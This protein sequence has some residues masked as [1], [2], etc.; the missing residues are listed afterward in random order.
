VT[1]PGEN[2]VRLLV[3]GDVAQY[4]A[5]RLA[6]LRDHPEAYSASFELESAM[7][8]AFFIARLGGTTDGAFAG[9]FGGFVGE[10]L[11]GITGM[12]QHP[13][14]KMRHGA[15]VVSVYVDPAHRR[16]GHAGRLMDAVTA[17]ARAL[18]LAWLTLDVTVGNDRARNFYIARGF[19]PAG[20]IRRGLCVN[21][22]Y[23]DEERMQLDL[24]NT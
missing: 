11:V 5:M 6:A 18:G 9:T 23:Y 4:R 8:D 10:T 13:A 20:I 3:P 12:R 24:D 16:G 14:A 22:R 21:G 1:G 15:H 2:Q 7:D 17:Q 19:L